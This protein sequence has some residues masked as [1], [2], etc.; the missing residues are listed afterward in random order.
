MLGKEHPCEDFI[1]VAKSSQPAEK[2]IKHKSDLGQASKET[3][4]ENT[5]Y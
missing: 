2:N 4:Q 5:Q 1:C 3:P